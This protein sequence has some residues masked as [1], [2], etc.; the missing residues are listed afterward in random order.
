MAVFNKSRGSGI[1][2]PV[3]G[4]GRHAEG[5]QGEEA[6]RGPLQHPKPS[7]M[8]VTPPSLVQVV[9][10]REGIGEL[11]S[12]GGPAVGKEAQGES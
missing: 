1:L 11:P 7:I 2:R 9:P 10:E 6:Q 8:S 4:K 12:I 3:W 5:E